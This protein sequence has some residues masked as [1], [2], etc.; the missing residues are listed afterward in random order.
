MS[1][2]AFQAMDLTSIKAVVAELRKDILP[3]RFEKAQQPEPNSLQIGLRTLEGLKWIEISWDSEAPRFVEISSPNKS[4]TQ[5]TLAR[6]IQHGLKNLALVEIAQEG[7]ERVI[8]IS[9]AIRPNDPVKKI[10]VLELMGRHSNL[11]LLDH[12]QKIITLGRQIRSHQSRLRPISTG[13]IYL[14]PPP[15]KGIKPNKEESFTRWKERLSLVPIKLKAALQ[16]NYQGISPSLAMQLTSEIKE[17]SNEILNLEVDKISSGTWKKIHQRWIIWLEAIEKDNF[18]LEFKGPTDFKLWGSTPTSK[19]KLKGTSLQLGNYY[20]DHLNSRKINQLG[21]HIFQGLIK[22]KKEELAS[23]DRQKDLLSKTS[24]DKLLQE[25]ADKILCLESPN[26]EQIE[27]AQKLYKIAKKLRRSVSVIK[28]RIIYHQQ[29]VENVEESLN[30]LDDLLTTSWDEQ[31]N[32]INRL[33]DLKNELEEYLIKPKKNIKG[34]T[35]KATN[36]PIPLEVVSANGALIQIGRNHRQNELIS[37]KKARKGDLWFHAQECSGSHVVLK[38]SIQVSTEEDVQLAADM[39]ALFSR[40]KGNKTVPVIIAPAERLQ[41]IQTCVPGTVR[42]QNGE[43]I[44]GQP[45]RA[46]RYLPINKSQ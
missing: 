17:N 40:G 8:Q 5:S 37:L 46:L 21:K 2:V 35:N 31:S 4:G 14:S 27:K 39:A 28:E 33:I 44:W 19:K 16:S 29:K 6:Q 23:L 30:F 3:S 20:R 11:F 43:I 38:S 13:D 1:S 41:R 22:L 9:F 32:K 24:E 26:K 15:L 42:H 7:F 12:H 25:K 34:A 45:E 36:M 10:L 18:R